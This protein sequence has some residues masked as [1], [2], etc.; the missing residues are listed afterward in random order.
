MLIKISIL[1]FCIENP[2]WAKL[3]S[4]FIPE[5]S[6]EY[7]LQLNAEFFFLFNESRIKFSPKFSTVKYAMRDYMHN[8]RQL[9]CK[10]NEN[11]PMEQ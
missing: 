1:L 8:K 6:P 9:F 3:S 5:L 4:N 7:S 11:I 2:L 10:A